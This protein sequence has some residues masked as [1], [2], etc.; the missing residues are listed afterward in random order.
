MAIVI[1]DT[2]VVIEV[3]IGLTG[4]Q[5]LSTYELAVSEGF[6]GTLAEWLAA[7]EADRIQ[8]GLD[9]VSTSASATAASISAAGSEAARLAAEAARDTAESWAIIANPVAGLPMNLN[10]S[11]IDADITIPA[12]Y[13]AVSAGPITI[14]NGVTVT[15]ANGSSWAI[16]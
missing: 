11:G 1:E 2:V 10:K 12:G 4:A 16:V 15:A 5:G 8:T 14:N 3:P 9:V 13:N 6:V 7:T